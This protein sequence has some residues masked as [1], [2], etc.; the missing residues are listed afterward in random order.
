MRWW[1]LGEEQ[2]RWLKQAFIVLACMYLLSFALMP[3]VPVTMGATDVFIQLDGGWRVY[4]GQVPHRDFYIALG[5]LE[6]MITAAGM[7]LTKASPKGIAIGN[8]LFAGVAAVWGWVLARRRMSVVPAL[9]VTA[10]L[11]LTAMSPTPLGA[12]WRIISAAELY[13]RHGYILLGLILVECASSSEES[14][15]DGVSSGVALVA[16]FFLKLNFFGAAVMLLLGSV[17]LRSRDKQRLSGFLI[18]CMVTI[19]AFLIALHFQIG[20]FLSDMIYAT[21]SRASSRILYASLKGLGS[22]DNQVVALLL[23]TLVVAGLTAEKYSSRVSFVRMLVLGF[24]V[25]LTGSL[26]RQTNGGETGITLSALWALLLLGHA[27]LLY[28]QSTEKIALSAVV[29]LSLALPYADFSQDA[30]S[31]VNLLSYSRLSKRQAGLQISS[32]S[33]SSLRF[34][35][36]DDLSKNRIDNGT[37]Y[38]SQVDDGLTLLSKISKPQET[39]VTLGH[40]NPFSYILRRKPSRG[41]APWLLLNNNVSPQDMPAPERIIG[42]ADLL[43]L[44]HF[45]NSHVDSD[46]ALAKFYAGYIQQHFTLV[47]HSSMWTVYRRKQA[48]RDAH[49]EI[50]SQS[51]LLGAC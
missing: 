31:Y 34:Y 47:A 16:L 10:W 43:M 50:P 20:P 7:L 23:M 48:S 49:A 13:N 32:P 19:F 41:G 4:N 38:V 29:A 15:G 14:L 8:I 35:D 44:P 39:I 17:P 21:R 36:N 45:D 1:W 30:K 5:P 27:T 2:S 22:N 11:I 3:T 18:G 33:V 24:T 6:Y 51:C 42:D 26:L 40:N 28:A 12:Q 37:N 25:I 9:L 46:E